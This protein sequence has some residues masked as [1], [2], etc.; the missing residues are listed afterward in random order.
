MTETKQPLVAMIVLTWNQ[1]DLTLDC[2]ASLDEM[3]YPTDRLQVI[4]VDNG[5]TDGTAR[6]IRERYPQVKVLENGENLGFA[7]GNNVGIRSAIQQGVD[8]VM[9]LNNDTVVD[10]NMLNYLIEAGE[11]FPSAGIV[12]PKIYYYDDPKR[13][14]CAGASID[15]RTGRITRLQAD[16]LDTPDAVEPDRVDFASGCAICVKREVIE[17]TGLLDARFFI[18]YEETDW[19]VRANRSGWETLYVPKAH[20]WHKVSAAMG[21]TSPATDYYMNRNTLLFLAKNQSSWQRAASLLRVG[22]RNL[23]TILAYTLKP[24]QG[25]RIP[26]RNV[27]ILALRDALLGRWGKMGVDVASICYPKR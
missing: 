27:R 20:L 7:E 8:Y 21:K 9:L 10:A 12:A 22:G 15:W 3:N 25:Q 1:R 11:M 19:C 24:H 18:Y 2:L 16:E 14:W 23:L 26:N 13:I 6:G 4:V 17:Q 5:S